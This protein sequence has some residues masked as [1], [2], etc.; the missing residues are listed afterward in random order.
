[1][2]C[3]GGACEKRSY[4]NTNSGEVLDLAKIGVEKGVARLV[5]EFWDELWDIDLGLSVSNLF[6]QSSLADTYLT[7]SSQFNTSVPIMRFS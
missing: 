7:L 5:R 4:W 3:Q 2:F 1:V 6:L